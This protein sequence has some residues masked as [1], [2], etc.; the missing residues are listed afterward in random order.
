MRAKTILAAMAALAWAAPIAAQPLVRE[1]AGANP[2]GIQSAV[3]A[4]RADLGGVNNGNTPGSQ[5]SGRR[6]INWDGGGAAA[7][8]TL[9]PSPMTRFSNRG[10][11]FTTPGHGF[12][13]SGAPSPNFGEINPIY[14]THFAAFSSPRLFAARGSNV[15]DTWFFVPANTAIAAGVTG[16]GA[17]FT[18]V[19][20]E[21]TT[22]LSDG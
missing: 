16:F 2:A 15:L 6:E 17:V 4:F 9:D 7:T 5:P 8:P 10:A 18:G 21:G 20:A 22:R 12:E 19:S 3:D 1:A 11:V 13:I 14:G